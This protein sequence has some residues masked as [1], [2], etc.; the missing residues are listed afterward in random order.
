[1]MN[2]AL[3][4]GHQRIAN[5]LIENGATITNTDQSNLSNSFHNNITNN[6]RISQQGNI[7]FD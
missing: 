6:I 4:L 5:M 7:Y 3:I 1:M 2:V